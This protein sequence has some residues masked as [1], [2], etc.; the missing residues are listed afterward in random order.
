MLGKIKAEEQKRETVRKF[1]LQ[2]HFLPTSSFNITEAEWSVEDARDQ[3]GQQGRER[4]RNH[5]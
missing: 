4:E 2:E 3:I 5:S 1:E